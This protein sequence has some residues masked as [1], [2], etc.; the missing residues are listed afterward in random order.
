MGLLPRGEDMAHD[1]LCRCKT[2]QQGQGNLL[3]GS[4]DGLMA[5]ET[6]NQLR[7]SSAIIPVLTLAFPGSGTARVLLVRDVY[8]W[9]QAGPM[10]MIEF[11]LCV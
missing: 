6:G 2:R 4:L 8:S 5:A 9:H 3:Q 7:F 1:V 10:I 11:H